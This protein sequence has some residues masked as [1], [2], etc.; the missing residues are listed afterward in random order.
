MQWS[1]SKWI[2]QFNI[3][4]IYSVLYAAVPSTRQDPR[5][6]YILQL[7]QHGYVCSCQV[8]IFFLFFVAFFLMHWLLQFTWSATKLRICFFMWK[9]CETNNNSTVNQD[10]INLAKQ[11]DMIKI[12]K[13]QALWWIITDDSEHNATGEPSDRG[14]NSN[15]Q[16][17]CCDL[18]VKRKS[19]KR[20]K[21]PVHLLW[22]SI[23]DF[24]CRNLAQ[25]MGVERLRGK[26]LSISNHQAID[27]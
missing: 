26:K 20:K 22:R 8:E 14:H 23:Q 9:F 11:T 7:V 4:G 27:G 3:T 24:S 2:Q 21:L 1:E 19:V 25:N 13:H 6:S 15:S 12:V 5:K 10:L 17:D 18:R 16:T